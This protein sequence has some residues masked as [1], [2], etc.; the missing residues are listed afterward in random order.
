MT[1]RASIIAA[2]SFSTG[3]GAY[4]RHVG[5]YSAALAEAARVEPGE[6]TALDVGCGPGALLAELATRL[7]ADRVTGIDP[8]EPFVELC[9]AAVPG[10]DVRRGRAEGLPFGDDAFD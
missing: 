1:L 4:R 6:T 3:T 7:G 8:S 5:R 10:A 2:I 9:R